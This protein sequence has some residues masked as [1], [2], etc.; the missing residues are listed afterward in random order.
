MS[1][2]LKDA[3]TTTKCFQIMKTSMTNVNNYSKVQ[4]KNNNFHKLSLLSQSKEA[5]NFKENTGT[6]LKL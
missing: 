1:A 2:C 4:K 3:S 6:E 5:T